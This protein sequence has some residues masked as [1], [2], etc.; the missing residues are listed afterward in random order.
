[1][2]DRL[3]QLILKATRNSTL[4][5]V[6]FIDLDHFKNINDTLGHAVGDELLRHVARRIQ[7]ALRASDTLSRTGGDEF[8]VLLPEL[9]EATDAARVAEEIL[10]NLVEPL[11]LNEH[12]VVISASVGIAIFP[13]DGDSPKRLI[14]CADMAMYHSKECGRNIYLFYNEDMNAR[15][16]ERM[17]LEHR[18]RQGIDRKEF[19]LHYQP[20][21]SATTGEICGVEALA[22]WQHPDMGMISP[23]R[24]IPVAEDSGL[25]LRLGHWVLLEACRQAETWRQAGIKNIVVAVNISAIQFREAS[26]VDSVRAVLTETGLP[27][28][29]LEL[30]MTESL[31]MNRVE[32]TISRL[33]ELKDSGVKLSIDDFGTGYSALTY[34]KRFPIDKLKIDQSFVRGIV[35]DAQ[36]AAIVRAIIALADSLG[37]VSIAEGVETADVLGVLRRL[38]CSEIQGY[39]YSRPLPASEAEQ[40]IRH[41]NAS[42]ALANQDQS[43]NAESQLAVA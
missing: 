7:K 9:R 17:S 18:M 3:E 23:A 36:D 11:N 1:M 39:F 30:E 10:A 16:F 2:L 41:W 33:Q 13:N 35:D 24:F 26:F 42:A 43:S 32:H 22:R 29:L 31:V 37:L 12:Q 40:K 14:Q 5:G 8:I 19:L 28:H 38:G 20:Q 34:L 27:P 21:V 25:I 4:L 6:L 15:V